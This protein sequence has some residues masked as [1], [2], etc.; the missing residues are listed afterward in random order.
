MVTV[1]VSVTGAGD[2]CLAVVDTGP[3]IPEADFAMLRARLD[4]DGK[5]GEVRTGTRGLGL[6]I[7]GEIAKALQ[8]DIR[9]DR[10]EGGPGLVWSI[11]LPAVPP[12]A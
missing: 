10:G 2:I 7:V 11:R 6:H 4:P 3:P 9:L 12:A 5:Q 8:A 1:Q